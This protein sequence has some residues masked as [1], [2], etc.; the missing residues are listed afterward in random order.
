MEVGVKLFSTISWSAHIVCSWNTNGDLMYCLWA[1]VTCGSVICHRLLWIKCRIRFSWSWAE[2][3][4]IRKLENQVF[5]FTLVSKQAFVFTFQTSLLYSF[6]ISYLLHSEFDIQ[7]RSSQPWQVLSGP[8]HKIYNG[9]MVR[10]LTWIYAHL[11]RSAVVISWMIPWWQH[12]FSL[13]T[14][15]GVPVR[16][17]YRLR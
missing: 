7:L 14:S 4:E 16:Y 1:Y 5:V 11:G 13:S 17:T 12:Y 8:K 9:S 3:T 10:N 6:I 2:H 15:Y